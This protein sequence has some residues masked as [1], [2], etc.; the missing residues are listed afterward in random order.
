MA[1]SVLVKTL[2]EKKLS[3]YCEKRM[4]PHARH[5]VRLAYEIRGNSVTIFEERAPWHKDMTEWTSM[6][7]AQIRY[8]GKTGKWSLYC[9]DR[10][11]RWHKYP[12]QSPTKDLDEILAEINRDPTHIFWG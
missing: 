9:A 8:D 6:P 4:P 7:I 5:Q 10:N 1:L 12:G 3:A 11:E 2:D